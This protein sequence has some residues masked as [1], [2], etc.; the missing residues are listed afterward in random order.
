M[1]IQETFEVPSTK[2]KEVM[3]LENAKS[4]MT[5]IIQYL[6]HDKLLE[7]EIEARRIKRVSSRYLMVVDQLYKM[8][9]S[10]LM[11]RYVTE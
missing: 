1:V 7:E 6:T 8:G 4:W 9:I 3:V 5:P 10:S 2:V 11:L